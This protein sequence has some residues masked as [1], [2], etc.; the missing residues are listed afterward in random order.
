[1]TTYRLHYFNLKGRAE[2]SRLLLHIAGVPYEDV[3]YGTNFGTQGLDYGTLKGSGLLPFGQMPLLEVKRGEDTT[4]IAQSHSI[5]R[6]I[7]GLFGFLGSNPE[8]GALIDSICEGLLDLNTAYSAPN[9]KKQEDNGQ[10]LKEF[11]GAGF[12]TWLTF[13]NNFAQRNEQNGPGHFV[14]RSVSYADVFFFN[15][16]DGMD[17]GC[18]EVLEKFPLL[19]GIRESVGVS[20][21]GW[22]ETR[23][24]TPF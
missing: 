1:M 17:S 5:E 13:L 4:Y 9:K 7:A 11:W 23:P 21:I 14:G 3:R 22:V 19:K 8:E 2:L 10:A 16:L 6:Y 12:V 20:V 24:K 15:L 18:N